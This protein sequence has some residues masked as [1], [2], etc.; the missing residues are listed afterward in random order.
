MGGGFLLVA[1]AGIYFHRPDTLAADGSTGFRAGARSE[2]PSGRRSMRRAIRSALFRF[3]RSH[4]KSMTF[5]HHRSKS[6]EMGILCGS[7]PNLTSGRPLAGRLWASTVRFSHYF[8]SKVRTVPPSNPAE[9]GLAKWLLTEGSVVSAV[10]N[11]SG[12]GAVSRDFRDNSL[13]VQ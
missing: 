9:K 10:P 2:R 13:L 7:W 4:S 8:P 5:S 6:L 12:N 3:A 1:G 11:D